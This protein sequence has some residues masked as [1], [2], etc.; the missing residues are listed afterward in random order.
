MEVRFASIARREA[1]RVNPFKIC[2]FYSLASI[3]FRQNQ[4]S[5]S[6]TKKTCNVCIFCIECSYYCHYNYNYN[7][8]YS[9]L[10]ILRWE[11]E[12]Q[13]TTFSFLTLSLHTVFTRT[14]AW[15][16]CRHSGYS[17]VAW[18]DIPP[19]APT[20]M[21]TWTQS[22]QYN[23]SWSLNGL[24]MFRVADTS[25][26]WTCGSIRWQTDDQWPPACGSEQRV[27]FEPQTPGLQDMSATIWPIE[28][29]PWPMPW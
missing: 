15:H 1:R 19:P 14:S 27:G 10:I 13:E 11:I 16:S 18:S 28:A 5:T 21:D 4:S 23:A 6:V 20:A 24:R 2:H 8:I 12:K 17:G 3:L 26:Q 9:Y 22:D 25:T 7:S 29:S